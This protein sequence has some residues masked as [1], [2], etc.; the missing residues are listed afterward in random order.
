M[1]IKAADT[2]RKADDM[3]AFDKDGYEGRWLDVPRLQAANPKAGTQ[4]GFWDGRAAAAMIYNYYCKF[5]EKADEMVG[6]DEGDKGPGQNGLKPNLRYL[7]GSQKGKFAGLDEGGKVDVQRVFTAAG[8]QVD[9]GNYV[10]PNEQARMEQAERRLQPIIDQLKKNNPVLLYTAMSKGEGG[11]IV[12]VSGYKKTPEGAL[13]LRIT[14]PDAPRTEFLAGDL[15]IVAPPG[16]PEAAFSEYWI[17]AGRLF[18][19]HPSQPPKRLYSYTGN[20]GPYL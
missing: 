17:K 10:K 6:H 1:T 9:G 19:S 20:W 8:M 2:V 7:G 16:G 13:W 12:V 15:K 4:S 11:H 14:D 18:A 3:A 5:N